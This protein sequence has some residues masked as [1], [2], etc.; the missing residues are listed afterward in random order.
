MIILG[1]ILI[2]KILNKGFVGNE[3][4]PQKALFLKYILKIPCVKTCFE[5]NIITPCDV[6][7]YVQLVLD[8]LYF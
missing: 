5:K 4:K 3:T 1:T 7:L 8:R 2:S 6:L